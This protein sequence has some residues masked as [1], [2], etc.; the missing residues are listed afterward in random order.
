MFW[1]YLIKTFNS[2][3]T[4]KLRKFNFKSYKTQISNQ[5]SNLKKTPIDIAN[6]LNADLS[7]NIIISNYASQ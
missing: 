6:S 4:F 3:K 5:A 7:N 1:L 2:F